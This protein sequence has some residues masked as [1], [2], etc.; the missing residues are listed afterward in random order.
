[1]TI[2]QSLQKLENL[3]KELEFEGQKFAKEIEGEFPD[4]IAGKI[5]FE[6]SKLKKILEYGNQS[7]Q[8][9]SIAYKIVEEQYCIRLKALMNNAR[10]S[11]MKTMLMEQIQQVYHLDITV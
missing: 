5:R 10:E 3:Q 9:E 8:R 4:I 11:R 2:S 7:A 1:M 6:D